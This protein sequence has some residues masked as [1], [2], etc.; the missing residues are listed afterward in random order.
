[1]FLVDS[2]SEDDTGLED[3]SHSVS[4]EDTIAFSCVYDATENNGTYDGLPHAM[5]ASA[6][7]S[8]KKRPA[9]GNVHWSTCF[10]MYIG[11]ASNSDQW[12]TLT[13]PLIDQPVRGH[14]QRLID[15]KKTKRKAITRTIKSN[16][17]PV[18]NDRVS[19][20]NTFLARCFANFLRFQVD[21][22]LELEN[23]HCDISEE[24]AQADHF[25]HPINDEGGTKEFAYWHY[26][27]DDCDVLLDAVMPSEGMYMID[28]DNDKIYIFDKATYKWLFH[29]YDGVDTYE[30]TGCVYMMW[31]AQASMDEFCTIES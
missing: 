22:T 19:T 31:N 4:S 3:D 16:E 10:E 13:S 12:K 17:F 25:V 2:D 29:T 24:I 8:F 23:N 6:K 5:G 14:Y 15:E 9:S 27:V 7:P 28:L 26:G 18:E 20:F 11:S 21:I 30:S 1:M